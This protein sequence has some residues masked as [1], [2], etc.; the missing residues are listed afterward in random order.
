MD[1]LIP[2]LEQMTQKTWVD[3]LAIIAPLVLS[4]VAIYISISTTRK[5]NR[6]ALFEKRYA[7]YQKIQMFLTLGD[8]IHRAEKQSDVA[9]QNEIQTYVYFQLQENNAYPEGNKLPDKFFVF[10][11]EHIQSYTAL[12][13]QIE[14]L[15][16]KPTSEAFCHLHKELEDFIFLCSAVELKD[17]E[18]LS[19]SFEVFKTTTMPLIEAELKMKR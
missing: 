19:Q 14:F 18:K 1:E 15:F 7:L 10:I 13:K 9:L 4:V 16:D 11:V 6:I 17:V 12:I 2:I 5:Q 8:A 3:Y